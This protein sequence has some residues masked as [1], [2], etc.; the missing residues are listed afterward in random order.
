MTADHSFHGESGSLFVFIHGFP[1]SETMWYSMLPSMKGHRSLLL[2]LPTCGPFKGKTETFDETL[3]RFKKTVDIYRKNGEKIHVIGHDFG[4]F[5]TQIFTTRY[6]EIVEKVYLIDIGAFFNAG[7][8]KQAS[9]FGKFFSIFYQLSFALS[10]KLTRLPF[11]GSLIGYSICYYFKSLFYSVMFLK[12][13]RDTKQYRLGTDE[14]DPCQFFLYNNLMTARSNKS[15]PDLKMPDHLPIYFAYGKTGL[16]RIMT[17]HGA[18]FEKR[19]AANPS[20]KVEVFEKSGHWI[21][22]D[23]PNRLACSIVDFAKK[24]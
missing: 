10:Y 2:N 12:G 6:S 23:E 19:T 9:I 24:K 4:S 21:P 8:P 7:A 1:D 13:E 22:L 5:Y 14:F 3:S 15:M 16:K 20:C 18:D 11:I 17:W